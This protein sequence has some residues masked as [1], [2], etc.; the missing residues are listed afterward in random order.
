ME[1]ENNQPAKKNDQQMVNA[2]IVANGAMLIAL[3]TAMRWA[4]IENK[5]MPKDDLH[6]LVFRISS[7]VAKAPA[8][9]FDP[10]EVKI[11]KAQVMK[12]VDIISRALARELAADNCA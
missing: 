8:E 3:Q 7:E 4:I 9:G 6:T 2:T 10:E 5:G 12:F 11:G 1:N